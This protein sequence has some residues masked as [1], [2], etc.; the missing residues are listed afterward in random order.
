M[1]DE[2]KYEDV[3]GVWF[4]LFCILLVAV[5]LATVLAGEWL[6]FV[7]FLIGGGLFIR[8]AIRKADPVHEVI[9][10]RLGRR[11]LMA[12]E[13]SY[14]RK[15]PDGSRGDRL[16]KLEISAPG[17]DPNAPDIEIE[18]KPIY[19][20]KKEGLRIAMPLVERFVQISLEQQRS[21]INEQR[22]DE[23]EEEFKKRK[24]S[25]TTFEG[26]HVIPEVVFFWEV[27]D[28][29]K[30]FA[31]GGEI[32][33]QGNSKKAGQ[34]VH[35]MVLSGSREVMGQME[36]TQILNR[37]I[38]HNGKMIPLGLKVAFEVQSSLN[39]DKFGLRLVTVRVEDI[40]PEPDAQDVIDELEK[41]KKAE[42]EK[43][44][45]R[46]KAEADLIVRTTEAQAGLVE[47]QKEA[48]AIKAIAEANLIRAQREASGNRANL[49]AF[50]GKKADETTTPEDSQNYAS[51]QV[52]LK[53]AESLANNTKVVVVPADPASQAISGLTSIFENVRK[54]QE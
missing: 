43:E 52:G 13:T 6:L 36:L 39:W 8:A 16:I 45:R 3:F 2:K 5:L 35:D 20:T 7:S 22:K 33:Q 19:L 48:E 10:L 17:F 14:Y 9:V 12:I 4:P 51:Y 50:I 46:I 26:V 34:A 29:N 24:E 30:V 54:S 15:R 1:N 42:L 44:Q 38:D 37:V 41:V 53:R 25:F 18:K 27:M 32:D 23:S 47:K 11:V 31:L 49:L 40:R 21:E 28:A